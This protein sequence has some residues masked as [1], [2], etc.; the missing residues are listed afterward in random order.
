[1]FHGRA[2][3]VTLGA[4][5][6]LSDQRIAGS[7]SNNGRY[8][9]SNSTAA[10]RAGSLVDFL[11]DYTFNA[12]AYPN[13]GCP[14][15]Y[16][17]PHYF[18]FTAFTQTFGSQPET[19]FHTSELSTFV[20][21]RWRLT[22]RLHIN[23]GV[24]YQFNRLPPPQHPNA[25]MD[26]IFGS[27]AATGTTPSDTNNL[28]PSVGIAYA[29]ATNTV[30][31]LSYGYSFSSIPGL[32]LQRALA[33]TA[34]ANSQSQLRI[35]PRTIIDA[36]CTSYG[37]NFGYP[38]TYTCT[39]F[40]PIAAA[41]A[42]WAFA[43]GF[44]L[45]AVQTAE[46]SVSQQVGTRTHVSGSYVLALS[47]QLTNTV[48]I[49]IAPSTKSLA[50]RIVRNG[51]EPGAR[52][53]DIVHIP[54]YTARKTSAFGPVT[55]IL[56]NGN[57]TYHAM[58]LTLEHQTPRSLTLRSSW[59]FGKSLDTVRSGASARNEDAQLDP[60]QPL[61]DRAPSN[62]DHRHRVTA[63]AI[64]QPRLTSTHRLVNA[65]ANNWSLAPV[66]V[67]QSGRPYSYNLS[68]GTSVPGGRES[69]NGSGG[70]N[71]LPSVGRNTLRLPWT[72][73]IDLSLSRSFNLAHDHAHLRLMLQAFNALNHVN[74]TTV[75]QQ[76]FLIGTADT[77]GTIPLTYQDAPTLATEGLSS[78]PFG[79][80]T[81]SANS[82]TRERRLQAG[83]RLQW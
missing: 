11:T 27:L 29:P 64:W 47:R 31:H 41:G 83:L 5:I 16:A 71:Y 69:L 43:R 67:F 62:F 22:T 12:N 34:Q 60:F 82:P 30:I 77:N 44:Q 23:A 48:D 66:M 57:G 15:V 19:R 68:G 65:I 54:L 20:A 61:Y 35:A 52:S 26:A 14:S 7:E 4:S 51:G 21:D 45:P 80:P 50:F 18:C 81:Q 17:Q 73:S 56:S 76:A 3:Q 1:H 25:A 42:A 38:A 53:G 49:N 9:Y 59:T 78:K 55:A 39:P 72:Q 74:V 33:N 32:V 8:L 24:R 13:G 70:A 75:E 10:G 6:L 46:L 37:T 40:G 79:T 28:A 63:L 58:A 2:H 36:G